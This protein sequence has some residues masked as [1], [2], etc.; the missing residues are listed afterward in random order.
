MAPPSPP[1][2]VLSA[3]SFKDTYLAGKVIGDRSSAVVRE[4]RHAATGAVYAV[5]AM[6]NDKLKRRHIQNEI[7]ALTKAKHP[8]CVELGNPM[9][10]LMIL[11]MSALY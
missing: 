7:T 8:N 1:Q 10:R 11:N 6:H 4:C 9:T 2:D 5:K 3:S